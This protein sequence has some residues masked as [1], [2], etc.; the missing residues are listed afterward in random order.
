MPRLE[1]YIITWEDINGN[2][3][4]KIVESESLS[5]A[6]YKAFKELRDLDMVLDR[7]ANFFTFLKYLLCEAKK[8]DSYI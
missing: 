3:C 5:K 6:K 7:R 1:T 8:Y 4:D 2:K